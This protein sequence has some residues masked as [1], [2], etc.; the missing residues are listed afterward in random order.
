MTTS[1]VQMTHK[2][3]GCKISYS[4]MLICVKYRILRYCFFEAFTPS[5]DNSL[6][7]VKISRII[8]L[9]FI[10][11]RLIICLDNIYL[12]FLQSIEE[13]NK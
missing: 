2:K 7:F 1:S 12:V 6:D 10:I 3:S 4:N 8:C 9:D 11:F 13:K 5:S